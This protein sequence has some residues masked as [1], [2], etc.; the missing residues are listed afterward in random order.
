M[1]SCQYCTLFAAPR[2]HAARARALQHPTLQLHFWEALLATGIEAFVSCLFESA[3]LLGA[4][5]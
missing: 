3:G 1:H 4:P 5:C 2:I